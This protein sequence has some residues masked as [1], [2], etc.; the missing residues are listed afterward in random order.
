MPPDTT[1]IVVYIVV[2]LLSLS[3]HE[4][5]HAKMAD[6]AGDDT[7]RLMGRVTLV[8]WKHWDPVGTVMIVLTSISGVGIG[9]GKPVIVRPERMRNPRWDHFWSVAAGPISNLILA[10]L[11]AVVLRVLLTVPAL[12]LPPLL[13]TVLLVGV[14]ANT[15]LALFNLLPL[16]PLDGHWLV[17]A[18]LPARSRP[19]WYRF[20]QTFGSFVLLALVLIPSGPFDL[21]GNLLGPVRQRVM[22]FLLGS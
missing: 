3:V 13:V 4:F 2:I 21:L 17:G 20:N 1:L 15:G 11:C 19:S 22:E 14:M 6:L 8:P 16:G 7:P 12:N 5:A 18:L 9:W 10:G